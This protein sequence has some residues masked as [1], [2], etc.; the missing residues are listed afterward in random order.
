MSLFSTLLADGGYASYSLGSLTKDG[1]KKWRDNLTDSLEQLNIYRADNRMDCNN[2]LSVST[3]KNGKTRSEWNV[4]EVKRLYVDM[5]A[6]ENPINLDEAKLLRDYTLENWFDGEELPEPSYVIFSGRGLQ[7][8]FTM[9]GCTNVT[10]WKRYQSALLNTCQKLLEELKH[11]SLS[12]A[13]IVADEHNVS[14][15]MLKDAARVHRVPDTTNQK[16]NVDA[17]LLYENE[18]NE[19]TL[20]ELNTTFTAF[21]DDNLPTIEE[22]KKTKKKVKSDKGKKKKTKSEPTEREVDISGIDMNEKQG[23]DPHFFEIIEKTIKP[24]LSDL[25]TLIRLRNEAGTDS[26]YRN[27]LIAIAIPTLVSCGCK[28][29]KVIEEAHRI[30]ALFNKPLKNAEVND[31]LNSCLKKKESINADGKKGV[32]RV[33]YRFYTNTIIDKLQITKEE[34][35][36]MQVLCSEALKKKRSRDKQKDI[37]NANR[38]EVYKEKTAEKRKAKEERNKRIHELSADGM[39]VRQIAKTVGASVGTVSKVLNS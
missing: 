2:Y 28:N 7:F 21:S 23:I 20:N 25:E 38:R 26:G 16:V 37:Q 14:I 35:E 11:H 15:D 5:D 36:E 31:W 3:F 17:E 1:R 8:L 32:S 9:N 4:K 24:R 6:H 12:E 29:D 22:K 13:S 18:S 39:S 19:Y 27:N 10:G 30:N 33:Y 34:Q